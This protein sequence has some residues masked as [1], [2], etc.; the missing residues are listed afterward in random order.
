LNKRPVL[1]FSVIIPVYN[2][3]HLILRALNSVFAQTLQ[4]FEIIVVDDGSSDDIA[5]TMTLITDTRVTFIRQPNAGASV[6]RNVGIDH[7][8]GRF[9]AFLDSDD[10]FLPQHLQSLIGLLRDAEDLAV[11]SPVIVERGKG[12][13]FV[14]PPRGIA[15]D[16]NMASYLIC[17][18]G[19]VQTSGLALPA[20]I[21]RRVRYR[22]DAVFGDDT[23]FA[24]RLQLAGCKFLMQDE[25]S[26]IWF[27]GW[28]SDR[29]SIGRS[30]VGELP[31]LEDLRGYIPRR[32]YYGY[33]GWH[34]AKSISPQRPFSALALFL[35]A[36]LYGAFPPGLAA[37]IFLQIF[38]SDRTY[39][40]IAD[41]RVSKS[42]T[43]GLENEAPSDVGRVR[44]DNGFGRF[45]GEC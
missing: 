34:F 45:S 5:G 3:A 23:D 14:K 15:D 30:S 44:R 35:R 13:S 22:A 36:V 37:Q 24:I 1:S 39:R 4:D 27:D 9:V 29:L 17:N 41:W 26:V 16:E 8:R 33:R 38:L 21:A 7:A 12:N 32:A 28:R 19:F 11:Y 2:R 18:R 10:A 43:G 25:P 20:R 31:W 40:K 6:A 42:K